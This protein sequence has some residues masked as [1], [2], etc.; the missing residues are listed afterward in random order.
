MRFT[1]LT[2]SHSN[3]LLFYNNNIYGQLFL[4]VSRAIDAWNVLYID[5]FPLGQ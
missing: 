4:L 2:C 3:T 5:T 1:F